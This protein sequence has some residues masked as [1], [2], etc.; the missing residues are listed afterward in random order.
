MIQTY[1]NDSEQKR[2]QNIG[3]S[4]WVPLP[5]SLNIVSIRFICVPFSP[6]S[7]NIHWKSLSKAIS[8]RAVLGMPSS[9]GDRQTA[10]NTPFTRADVTALR[11]WLWAQHRALDLHLFHGHQLPRANGFGLEDLIHKL[12]SDGL[13]VLCLV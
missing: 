13:M 1:S 6:A 5:W 11:R 10:S 9:F 7:L 3:L 2:I 8:R 12:R 4:V